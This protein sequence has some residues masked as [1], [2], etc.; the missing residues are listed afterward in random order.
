MGLEN[1]ILTRLQPYL[2]EGKMIS[3]GIRRNGEYRTTQRAA[4]LLDPKFAP[5]MQPV[6]WVTVGKGEN[7]HR[8]RRIGV[9]PTGKSIVETADG[10][11]A[12]EA[13]VELLAKIEKS[14]PDK[15]ALIPLQIRPLLSA[16]D[17]EVVRSSVRFEW[18]KYEGMVVAKA[19]GGFSAFK[20][21]R[22]RTTDKTLVQAASSALHVFVPS[23]CIPEPFFALKVPVMRRELPVVTPPRFEIPRSQYNDGRHMRGEEFLNLLLAKNS[24]LGSNRREVFA[25]ALDQARGS[26]TGVARVLGT[27]YSY[28]RNVLIEE[29]LFTPEPRIKLAS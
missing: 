9:A 3:I 18:D 19:S 14:E 28:A 5:D 1:H 17:R 24:Q 20:L 10:S 11:S 25:S 21:R 4:V 7:E 23:E 27:S 8:E 12:G 2:A 6:E 29:G 22:E 13:L 16:L 26:V 15:A